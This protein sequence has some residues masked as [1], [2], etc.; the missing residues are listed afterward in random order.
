M[1][2]PKLQKEEPELLQI[3]HLGHSVIR[4]VAKDV[5]DIASSDIQELI[6]TM[7]ATCVDAHGVGLAA[8]QVYKKLRLFVMIPNSKS[9]R[10]KPI[11]I[12]NP[13]I[14]S[15]GKDIK[16]DWEGCLSIPGIRGLVPRQ[17]L[18][19]VEFNNREGKRIKKAF[20]DFD[21]RIFQH[22]YDHLEG[23]VFL[24]RTDSKD[25]ITEKEYQKL[26]KKKTK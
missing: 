20:K 8:P 15:V 18:I 19:K 6:E 11:A 21:A 4:T 1:T 26:L 13:K 5:A 25:L 2:K 12:I 24:D 22:E 10:A 7:F 17:T 23:I 14:I 16:K 3:A 9:P